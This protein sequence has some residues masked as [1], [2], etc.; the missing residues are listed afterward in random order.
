MAD[1]IYIAQMDISPELEDDFNRIY[2]TQHVPEILTVGGRPWLY[3][4]CPRKRN[5]RGYPQI[6]G[7]LRDRFSGGGQEPRVEGGGRQG[8]TGSPKSA[9]IR[10]T[11]STASYKKLA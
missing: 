2:D 10:R 11:A 7:G 3:P 9:P 6:R 8:A 5:G 1:Y 4:V